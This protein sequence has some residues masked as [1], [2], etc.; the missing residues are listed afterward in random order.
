MEDN[1]IV[2]RIKSGDVQ[3]FAALV[4]RHH[5][6]LL[7]YI[8]RVVGDEKIVEDIGQE[9]FLDAYRSLKSFDETRGTPFS[10]WLYVMARNRCMS[11]LRKRKGAS[12][13]SIDEVADLATNDESAEEL[14]IEDER[15]RAVSAGLKEL[16][17]PFRSALVM[18]L[19]GR[20]LKEIA[21]SWGVSLGTAKSRLGRAKDKLRLLVGGSIGGKGY[22]RI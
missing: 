21:E 5:R 6:G 7:A 14:L 16:P 13:V 20:T 18:S 19:A 3:A 11:E 9:V 22:E 8:H 1:L 12:S 17:D 4:E 15:R 10:A 2:E